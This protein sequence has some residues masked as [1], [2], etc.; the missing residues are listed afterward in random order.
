MVRRRSCQSA[1][2]QPSKE[3]ARSLNDLFRNIGYATLRCARHL[4]AESRCRR[5][6]AN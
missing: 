1:A 2:C 4:Y 5:F 6:V 3:Q